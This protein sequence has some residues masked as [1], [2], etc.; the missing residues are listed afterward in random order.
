MRDG[1]DAVGLLDGEFG[2][3][4]EA[5]IVPDQRDVGAVEGGDERQAP[6]SRHGAREQRTHRVRNR[7][8][9]VQ[10]VE[11]LGFGN[12]HHFDGEG[13]RV[14]RVI[15]KRV[16]R[17]FDFV[18]GDVFRAGIQPHGRSV[19]DEVNVV[20]ARGQLH[21]ELGGHDSGAAVG[22]IAG[23]AYS[24]HRI[25]QIHGRAFP[26]YLAAHFSAGVARVLYLK[27]RGERNDETGVGDAVILGL[28]LFGK[29]LPIENCTIVVQFD[30]YP[31]MFLQRYQSKE[32]IARA[33]R[34]DMKA[35]EL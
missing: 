28:V 14:G 11:M 4:Q 32:D 25:R 27:R 16:V 19:A 35:Q 22:G 3:G 23:D 21:A 33:V 20:P 8:M 17:D 26:E 12:L 7:V 15:E 13:Q 2:D 5:A 6:G 34:K 1:G 30:P 10:Q 18:E 9:N 31:P 29:L 24:H